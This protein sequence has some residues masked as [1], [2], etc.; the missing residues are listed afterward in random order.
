LPRGTPGALITDPAA[1]AAQALRLADRVDTLC[2]H[3][4]S[5]GAVAI[6]WAVKASLP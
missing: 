6:A 2:V 3:G 1:A 5:P 4:D